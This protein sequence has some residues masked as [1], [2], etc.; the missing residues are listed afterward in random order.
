VR[1]LDEILDTFDWTSRAGKYDG[2][3]GKPP[4]HPRVICKVLLYALSRRIRSSRQM[5]Y[6]IGH[7]IDFIW[8]VSG[9]SIDHTTLSEFRRKYGDEVKEIY[10]QLIQLA[11]FMGSAKLSEWWIDGT[12]VQANANRFKT[13]K[14][15]GLSKRI[16]DLDAEISEALAK[17]ETADAV[18]DLFEDGQPADELPT[19]LPDLQQR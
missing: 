11:I 2:K 14:A 5:E 4:I 1:L 3:S 8:L 10:K 17:M 15:E 13:Y 9:R 6:A 12:K 7:S 19:D 18:Q 16:K